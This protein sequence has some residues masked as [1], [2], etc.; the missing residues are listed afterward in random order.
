M[1]YSK[2]LSADIANGPGFRVS[3]WFSGCARKCKGCFNPESWCE[4]FGKKFDE[5]AKK[6]IYNE[7]E[8]DWC[9]GVTLLGGEPLS[10]LSN[11]RSETIRFCKELKKLYP[12]KT[13]M[14]YSGYTF[15]E[16][17][18]DKT[19]S[20]VLEYV[21]LVVDGPFVEEKKDLTLRWRGSSNQTIRAKKGGKWYN[22]DDE[23]HFLSNDNSFKN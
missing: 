3:I 1:N 19:M 15:D 6:K 8:N 11:N 16:I 2:I 14:L 17:S 13:I 10:K 4:T 9:C 20:E 21:D 22:L 12:S 7:L 5:T 23:L 18:S